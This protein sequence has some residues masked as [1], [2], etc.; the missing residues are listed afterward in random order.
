MSP[1][2]QSEL[3]SAVC[4]LAEIQQRL[5]SAETFRGFRA[6]TVAATAVFGLLAA[7]VQGLWIP[8]PMADPVGYIT[9]WVSV[10]LAG[11]VASFAEVAYRGWCSESPREFARTRVVIEQLLP[12]LLLGAAVTWAI[13]DW[14]PSATWLLPSLWSGLFGLGILAASRWLPRP[15]AWV[16]AYYLVSATLPLLAGPGEL[17]CSP[18]WMAQS[19]GVGQTALAVVLYICL[20]RRGTSSAGIRDSFHGGL[21]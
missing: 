10:A 12:S 11:S 9:L 18:W 16:G 4:Q 7:I 17:S 6:A 21:S 20:E 14:Q 3:R 1:I 19:F 5:S 13:C 15:V 2:S 8:V